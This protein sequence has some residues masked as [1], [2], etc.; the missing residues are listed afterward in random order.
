MPICLPSTP[1]RHVCNGFAK[2]KTASLHVFVYMVE[3]KAVM[4]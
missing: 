3:F 1:E 2:Y 4:N